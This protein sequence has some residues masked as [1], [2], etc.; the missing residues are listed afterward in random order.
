MSDIANNM[1]SDLA[2]YFHI[3]SFSYKDHCLP[4]KELSESI[5]VNGSQNLK[6]S[7]WIVGLAILLSVFLIKTQ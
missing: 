3:D 4:L 5:P 7:N 2:K 6:I 1:E